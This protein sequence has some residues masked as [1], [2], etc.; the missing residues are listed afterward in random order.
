MARGTP[1][2]M[3]EGRT[4]EQA[5]ENWETTKLWNVFF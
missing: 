1:E 3:E 2:D 4:G 5:R